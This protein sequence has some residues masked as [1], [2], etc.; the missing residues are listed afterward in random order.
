MRVL[1]VGDTVNGVSI[2]GPFRDSNAATEY[3][4]NMIQEAWVVA[5]LEQAETPDP[6]PLQLGE[7]R[8]N[9][10]PNIGAYEAER[11]RAMSDELL[12]QVQRLR[13]IA[14]T[15]AEWQAIECLDSASRSLFG[16]FGAIMMEARDASAKQEA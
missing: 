12:G 5:E 1:I 11:W 7:F 6:E 9:L 10:T 8:L 2:I 15:R 16:A 14:K 3:A 4:D 13:A